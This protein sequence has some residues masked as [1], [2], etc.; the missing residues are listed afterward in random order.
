LTMRVTKS[1]LQKERKKSHALSLGR[2]SPLLAR[3]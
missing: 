3:N 1:L 2:I